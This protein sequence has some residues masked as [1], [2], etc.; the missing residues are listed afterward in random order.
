MK[1]AE[2]QPETVSVTLFAGVYYKV[3]R[4]PAAGTVIPQHVHEHDHLTALLQG[5]VWAWRNDELLG[6]FR[7]PATLKIGAGDKHMFQTL[8][9]DTTL[10]CIHNADHLDAAEEPA[11][12]ALH[13]LDLED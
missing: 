9:D 3:W 10:A 1:R 4:V 11:V 2:R 12:A 5:A 7:A 13:A 8:V 6:S